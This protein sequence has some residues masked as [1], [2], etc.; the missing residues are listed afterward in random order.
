VSE[1]AQL[2]IERGD[3]F[4]FGEN[5][6]R[7]LELVDEARIH[8]AVDS[9]K[10]YLGVESLDGRTFIDVGCGSGL[11]SLA[12]RL[13]GAQ[14]RSFDFDPHSVACTAELRRR[15]RPNDEE[16]KIEQGSVLDTAY[17]ASLGKFDVVYSWGVLHHTG[18]MWNAL[19]NV[20]GLVRSNGILYIAIYNDQGRTSRNWKRVKQRYNQSGPVGRWVVLHLAAAHIRAGQLDISGALYRAVKRIPQPVAPAGRERGMDSRRDLVDWVGGWPFEVAKPEE[21]FDFFLGRDYTLTKLMTCGGG[22][23]CNQF[24][25]RRN[26]SD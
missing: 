9:L 13:M 23:G 6:A 14:V 21:V 4:A 15:Y 7:F 11:F 12:A 5:W 17:L 10:E 16:W 19:A 22:L 20:D 2:E 26:P 3:R 8:S 18:D 1:V 25:F 24:V